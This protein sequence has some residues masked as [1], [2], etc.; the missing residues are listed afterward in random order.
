MSGGRSFVE[1]AVPIPLPEALVYEVPEGVEVPEPGSRV[2]VP[3]GN[4]RLTGVV[5]ARRD[6]APE[7]VKVRPI[8]EV[9]D[10]EPALGKDLLKLAAFVADYYLA[11]IGDAARILTPADLPPWGDRRVTLTDAGAVAP[12]R[13]PL[14]EQLKDYLLEHRRAR[15]AEIRRHLPQP[16]LARLVDDMRRRGRLTVEDPGRRGSR[17]VS[18]VELMPGD[19]AE[20]L[21][22]CGRSELGRAA[23][24]YLDALQRPAT[25]REVAGAVGCSKSVVTRLASLGIL[26]EFSQPER[27]SLA[28]HRLGDRGAVEIVLR[29]DQ[30][31]V[32]G[33]LESA[34]EGGGFHPFLLRGST[35]TG[36]TEVYLRAVD[37]ALALGKSAIVLVPEIALVPALAH[38]AR[39][40]FGHELA[41]LH[42]NL[43]SAERV[44]EW[45]RIR[46]GEARVVLG[47]RSA[48][49]AP[50]AR[51]GV[52]IVDEEH[53]N[54]YKQDKSPRYN[55][56][57]LA[58]YRARQEGAIAVLVS[59]TPSLESRY[60]VERKKLRPL[61][62]TSRSGAGMPEGVLVD[63]REEGL[64]RRPGEV[65]FSAA[66]RAEIGAA[67]DEGGQVILL[68]NRRGYAP[69]LLCRACGEDF[70]CPDCG[71][72]MTL[73]RRLNRL[74]CH[75]CGHERQTPSVCPE[76]KEAALEPIGAGTERVEETFREIFPGVPVDV[77]DADVG[78]RA[79]GAAAVL[80]R[81][82]S[83]RT[84]VLIGTQM[85]AKGHDFPQVTLAAVLSAD[86]YLA[87][88][89]FRAVEK[90]YA[91]LTQ[92][93]GRSGRGD[94]PGRVVIQTFHPDHY[95]IRAAIEG[96]D[97]AFVEEEMRFR[98][99]FRYPPYTRLIQLL[100]QHTHAKKGEMQLRELARQLRAHPLA[101]DVLLSGPAPAPLERLRG[102]WR[103][104]LLLRGP[105]GTRLRQ[106]VREVVGPQPPSELTVDVDPYDLM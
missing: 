44:Q 48:L 55:G 53:E 54:A 36:K 31:E 84:R 104:Q 57:D 100:V 72:S 68:R 11:P 69:T 15:L 99:T 50:V 66:L 79:G 77:L 43:S 105:S 20:Q 26:R 97:R 86:T 73:H 19:R 10:L 4:R 96:D 93:A 6:E 38:L 42:S 83:G 37:K 61:E 63:L 90:T 102:K 34:V 7:G 39:R 80:E 60:N 71:L 52:L 32:V 23:V 33:V 98:R 27:L 35:G 12:A 103:F 46:G 94:R 67:L 59:A 5:T 8:L 82:S 81:F 87:F 47:P 21:E 106:L 56:R 14:E 95:A 65:H 29:P 30:A 74:I 91:L 24:Q 13:D 18:A 88:P 3:L 76:C 2:R 89:D 45:E 70:R 9:L 22:R 92:L 101:S 62:L 40:R 64:A 28:R 85:V 58:L 78:R 1:V 17:Y 41:I 75:Y 16:E 49:W 25:V 51:L